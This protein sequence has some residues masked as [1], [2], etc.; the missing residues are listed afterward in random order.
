MIDEAAAGYGSA[1]AKAAAMRRVPA[2]LAA[3]VDASGRGGARARPCHPTGPHP[4]L[5][6]A[7]LA[8]DS[9]QRLGAWRATPRQAWCYLFVTYWEEGKE[10]KET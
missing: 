6:K 5:T 8:V 1:S 7:R 2:P 9:E 3:S 10:A 4:S